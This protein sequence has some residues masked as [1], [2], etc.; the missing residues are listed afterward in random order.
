MKYFQITLKDE[1]NP[2]TCVHH[3]RDNNGIQRTEYD[4]ILHCKNKTIEMKIKMYHTTSSLDVQGRSPEYSTVYEA[5][6]NR[7]VALHFV[8]DILVRIKNE[9]SNQIDLNEVNNTCRDKAGQ[10]YKAELNSKKNKKETKHS[11]IPEDGKTKSQ[12]PAMKHALE[13]KMKNIKKK[14]QLVPLHLSQQISCNFFPSNDKTI[15]DE[16]S[17]VKSI[18]FEHMNDDKKERK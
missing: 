9:L 16:D 10:S 17:G 8:E 14:Q 12:A 4:L 6:G 7:T 15:A 1:E 11:K 13:L 5:F 18:E 2:T 3:I